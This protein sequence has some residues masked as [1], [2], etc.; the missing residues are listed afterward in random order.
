[1]WC[2]LPLQVGHRSDLQKSRSTLMLSPFGGR[3]SHASP[4]CHRFMGASWATSAPWPKGA[5]G[6]RASWISSACMDSSSRRS[7]CGP[8]AGSPLAPVEQFG[9]QAGP[10]GGRSLVASDSSASSAPW[11]RAAGR[12]RGHGGSGFESAASSRKLD[13]RRDR[14]QHQGGRYQIADCDL[15]PIEIRGAV[16][17]L[18][19][20]EVQRCGR[21]WIARPTPPPPPSS[22]M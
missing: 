2:R 13:E 5:A 22:R 15:Q 4:H 19:R 12:V 17:P 7:Q 8:A 1:V 14:Q 11:L 6:P 20:T 3:P 10:G 21:F 9:V 18:G 16:S